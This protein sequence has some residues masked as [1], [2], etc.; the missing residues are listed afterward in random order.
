M[1]TSTYKFTVAEGARVPIM[2]IDE[3]EVGAHCE[4]CFNEDNEHVAALWIIEAG[5]TGRIDQNGIVG[6]NARCLVHLLRDIGIY[7]DRTQ[8]AR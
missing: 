4:A 8:K 2:R 5:P 7:I 1:A 3:A 6:R